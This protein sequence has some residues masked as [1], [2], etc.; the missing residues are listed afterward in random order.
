MKVNRLYDPQYVCMT[1]SVDREKYLIATYL[2]RAGRNADLVARSCGMAIEQTTGTWL[3]VPGET[4]ELIERHVAKVVGLFEVPDYTRPT[5]IPD[6]DRSFV[7]RLAFPWDNFGQDFCEM[8]SAIPGNIAGGELKLL[9]IEMPGSFVEGFKGPKFGL[10]GVRD[11]LG[12]HDRPLVNNMIKPCAGVSPEDGAKF[13]YEAAIGGVDIIKDDELMAADRPYSPL[14]KR[15]EAYM[16]AAER[17]EKE[18]G[19]KT[20]FT[21]NITDRVDRLKSNAKRAINAGANAIMVNTFVVGLGAVRMLAEDPEI[22]VP[23]LG[24]GTASS[25]MTDSPFYG[26]SAE[27]F[28]GKLQRLAG[29]DII[30]D[31]VPY[32]KLPFLKEKYLRMYQECMCKFYDIKQTFVNAVAGTNPGNV[33]AIM[34]D[35]GSNIILGAGGAVHGHPMGAVAGGKALRQAIDATLQGISLREYA[36]SHKEL[37]EAIRVWGIHGEGENLFSRV[38]D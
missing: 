18:T 37:E 26:M 11:I 3:D 22:N 12:V 30:N 35:L 7:M 23:I 25:G 10:Q 27:L 17:A 20:L 19:E 15:V 32:G 28:N 34:A 9:D 13:F 21:V 24:H 33:P 5:Q 29:C 31:C 4:P 16:K 8:F 38:H 36:A 2:V 6:E 14:E 1:E